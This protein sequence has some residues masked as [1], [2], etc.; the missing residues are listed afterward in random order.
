VLAGL[1][2]CGPVG[3]DE[4]RRGLGLFPH[5]VEES[6]SD[7]RLVMN[8]TQLHHCD[9]AVN[10]GGKSFNNRVGSARTSCSWSW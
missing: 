6:L 10:G 3:C 5:Q 2:E 1:C 4:I 8:D 9:G 7:L